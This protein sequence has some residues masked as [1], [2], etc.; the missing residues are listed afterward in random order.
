MS[1]SISKIANVIASTIGT[2]GNALAL[3]A[4]V[5]DQDTYT[6]F[7]SMLEFTSAD[8][9]AAYY[10]NGSIQHKI[11]QIYFTGDQIATVLPQSLFFAGYAAA[12]K[13]GF[14]RGTSLAGMTIDTLKTITGSLSIIVGGTTYTAAS[15]D[16]SGVTTFTGAATALT[17]DLA[18]GSAAT[19]TW[20]AEFSCFVVTTVATGAAATINFA[21]GAAAASLGLSF[22]VVSNGVDADTPSSC[23]DR[24]KHQS[25]NFVDIM[26]S[27]EP[28]ASDKLLWGAWSS[29]QQKWY[30]VIMQ[31]S[32]ASAIVANN[33]SSFAAQVAALNYEG[34][35]P[36]Y[37]DYLTTAAICSFAGCID[38]NRINGRRRVAFT[39]YPGLAT[40]VTSDPI[41]DALL[42]NGYTFY[43]YYGAKADNNYSMMYNGKMP[44]S[45][46]RWFDT[47]L[48]HIFTDSQLQTSVV[49][50]LRSIGNAPY[51]E[52]GNT[53]IRA[54]C[55]DP[56]DQAVNNGTIQP[57]VALSN[58]QKA[59][60]KGII[61]FDVSA[62]LQQKGYYLYIGTASTQTRG[63]RESPPI[64]LIYTDG[65]SIQQIDIASIA[66]L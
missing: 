3:N 63:N 21:T 22:G 55:Q 61:G 46:D 12:N 37:G 52:R 66:V 33:A 19:V 59:T 14:L 26:F 53:Y 2:G 38:W 64:T 42:S 17:T 18:I 7:T 31:D 60:I 30:A 4:V 28:A 57:G 23:G 9:V 11:A 5:V 6:P 34:I 35:L 10:G 41:Y 50:G 62:D 16:L 40:D 24:F 49:E 15:I 48:G 65:G 32:D 58:A 47:Y 8:D 13:A 20:D 54:W 25:S 45:T 44:G 51:S 56:I 43:A 39:S 36:V 1:V 27:F 29:A